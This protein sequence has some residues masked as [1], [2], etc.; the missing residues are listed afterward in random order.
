MPQL[1]SALALNALADATHRHRRL[2]QRLLTVSAYP[3]ILLF[4]F[5][6]WFG[7]MAY[8]VFPQLAELTSEFDGTFSPIWGLLPLGLVGL[9]LVLLLPPVVPYTLK[10]LGFG[11]LVRRIQL[12][13]QLN[14]LSAGKPFVEADLA[15]WPTQDAESRAT[16]RLI[17]QR[18]LS[19]SEWQIFATEQSQQFDDQLPRGGQ[20]YFFIFLLFV[21][22]MIATVLVVLYL[23]LFGLLGI[24]GEL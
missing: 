3:L 1:D 11:E 18:G 16:R 17:E 15:D 7:F 14:L 6:V 13:L 4:I 9:N 22:A 2:H 12:I 8:T 23:P 24:A 20:V 21:L 19:P 10:W 5:A